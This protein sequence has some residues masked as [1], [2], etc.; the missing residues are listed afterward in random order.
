MEKREKLLKGRNEKKRNKGCGKNWKPGLT[1]RF[2]FRGKPF[3][4]NNFL[5]NVNL[6]KKNIGRCPTLDSDAFGEGPG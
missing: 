1:Y 6:E 3:S 4:Q 5:A 2:G